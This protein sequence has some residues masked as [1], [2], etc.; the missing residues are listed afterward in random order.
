MRF[1]AV[2]LA[3]RAHLPEPLR[4]E[5]GTL[6]ASGLG[7]L[8]HKVALHD[9][10]R[11]SEILHKITSLG[12][13]A[14]W[15]Q[16][17]TLKLSDF[18]D[19]L[20]TQEYLKQMDA[21]VDAATKGVKDPA[22]AQ[23]ITEQIWGRWAAKM[24]REAMQTGL[25]R[26]N[27]VAMS[28]ASGARGKPLQL[29]AM[30]T[31]PALFEDYRGR[32]VPIFARRSYAQ[33]VSPGEF[34]AGTFGARTS[35]TS[36]KVGTAKGG[37]LGKLLAQIASPVVV[38]QEDCGTRNGL[39]MSVEDMDLKNRFLARGASGL[40]DGDLVTRKNLA[41]L[42]NG[43]KRTV[44]VRSP[45]TCEAKEGI[46]AKCAG[47]DPRGRTFP[48]GEAVGVTAANA[49][50]EPATQMALNC[51]A[52]GTLVRMADF[53]VR[54]IEQIR[55]GDMV[56]G[57]DK[58]GN[59]FPVEVLHLHD[60]GLQP[61]QEYTFRRGQTEQYMQVVCTREHKLLVNKKVSSAWHKQKHGNCNSPNNLKPVK[62]PAGFKHAN[63]A[64]VLPVSF[65]GNTH[66]HEPLAL[67]G[68][69]LLGDGIR[70]RKG[71]GSSPPRMSCA[72]SRLVEDLNRDLAPHSLK[73]VKCKR[74]H[75]YR[76][77]T[78]KRMRHPIK[79]LCVAWRMEGKYA[80]EKDLP[81]GHLGWDDVSLLRLIAGYLATDGSIGVT[82]EKTGFVSFG[83]TSEVLLNSLKNLLEWRFG[84]Y[85]GSVTKTGKAG[86]GNRVHDMFALYLTRQD[87]WRKLLALLPA[88]PGIK[89][90]ARQRL[91]DL[92]LEV[93][94]PEPFFRALR[95]RVVELGEI[96]CFDISVDHP[97][98]LFVLANGVICSNS[99]HTSGASTIK[100]SYSGLDWMGKFVQMPTEFPDRAPIADTDG[101]ARIED[102]PQGGW[103]VHI[104][105]KKHYV[106][107]HLTPLVKNGQ[108]VEAGTPLSDGLVRASDVAQV[109]GLGQAR[110][111][112]AE[113]F[114]QMLKDSG[115]PG[116][117][118]NLE[119]VAR[120]AVNHVRVVDADPSDD[121]LVPDDVVPYD[122]ALN[123]LTTSSKGTLAAPGA[124]VGKYLR[125]PALH[126]TVGTKVTP[127]MARKL[128]EVEFGEIEVT[129][130]APKF[131]PDLSRLATATF[132]NPDW[133][134]SLGTSYL[135][136]QLVNRAGR[137]QDTNFKSNI[138]FAPRLM[139]GE[140]Y[141]ENIETTGKY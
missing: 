36:T 127:T 3:V 96:R 38:T 95:K 133:A 29:R 98:E 53:S 90:A 51:L 138:N 74:S 139:V 72:D 119:T 2:D 30:L 110:R 15:I 83:S 34:L 129:D 11:Y 58:D 33:G 54:P 132:A 24:E 48:I 102:A 68:G 120:A 61:V 104:G 17:E 109:E 43:K 116:S 35:V 64:A 27:A 10:E 41:Q 56:L 79:E 103:Y 16:G 130:E 67:V 12:R 18:E 87:Q 5:V 65:C 32:M 77:V 101:A 124:A 99:K 23:R 122:M 40:S 117:K 137:G 75:D 62:L 76:F 69:L 22:E 59:T 70:W 89:E 1:K 14:A 9:P 63:L 37:Y 92:K 80:H 84:I 112:W 71:N 118:R 111:Y 134:A 21:E 108:M 97:D 45:M 107:A 94:N 88:I 4:N 44:L 86:S 125:A 66:H 42:L 52:M 93:R 57:S 47:A 115:I 121:E 105:E 123:K 6:D 128:D 81:E 91:L 55:A 135:R 28:V 73:L 19:P 26:G 13:N 49:L 114:G 25:E 113:R 141:G 78:T 8:F 136:K 82:A 31:T 60:Q 140:G 20:P 131:A 126:Y 7:K 100:K 46:C 50:S 106:P 85:G 39:D